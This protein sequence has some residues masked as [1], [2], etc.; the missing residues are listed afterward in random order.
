M[1]C[2]SVPICYGA[3]NID[4]RVHHAR[5]KPANSPLLLKAYFLDT[6][7]IGPWKMPIKSY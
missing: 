7:F 6:I 1:E 2:K 3:V 5:S 4:N